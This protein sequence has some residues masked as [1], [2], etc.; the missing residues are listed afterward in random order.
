[1]S[2][3]P[4]PHGEFIF[5]M[6]LSDFNVAK[7]EIVSVPSRGIYIPNEIDRFLDGFLSDCFR[8]LTGNLY[9]KSSPS[10]PALPAALKEI[11]RG[12]RSK[13]FFFP[14]RA[15]QNTIKP[16]IYAARGKIIKIQACN[17]PSAYFVPDNAYTSKC[18][19]TLHISHHGNAYDS[20]EHR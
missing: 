7:A 6:S 16:S 18:A 11:S 15:P 5:Q 13:T 14:P 12:K 17:I 20:L 4:S 10:H 3:F 19:E 1:M 8:P 2:L 9:S